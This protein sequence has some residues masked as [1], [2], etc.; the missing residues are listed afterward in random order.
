[1]G[2]GECHILRKSTF[3]EYGGYNEELAAGEDFD[4]LEE[5]GK[6][7]KSYLPVILQFTNHLDDIEK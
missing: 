5:L 4:L 7:V 2:R 6:T 3:V 1:M